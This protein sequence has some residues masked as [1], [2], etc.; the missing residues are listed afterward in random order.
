MRRAINALLTPALP[1]SLATL[2]GAWR[3]GAHWL[4]SSINP[5]VGLAALALA[6]CGVTYERWRDDQRTSPQLKEAAHANESL[7]EGLNESLNESLNEGLNEHLKRA[8]WAL[9][10]A[11]MVSALALQ[12]KMSPLRSLNPLHPALNERA[13][14]ALSL[15][16]LALWVGWWAWRASLSP[17]R[18]AHTALPLLSGLFALPV[19]AWLRHLDEPLQVM[20]AELGLWVMRRVSD[21]LT[22]VGSDP[23]SLKSWDSY[24]FY[25]PNFYL[26]INE[27]C[28]GVNLLLSSAL[29]AVGFA[30]VMRAGLKGALTLLV[31]ALP[32]ALLLNGVRIALIFALGHF[33]SVELAM[34]AWHEG[35]AYLTQLPLL[36]FLA[37]RCPS[38]KRA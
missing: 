3:L 11:L 14:W 35:S 27:T 21:A 10:L 32:L 33:G 31:W 5:G 26:I 25:S 2:F 17:L 34:G 13:L 23:I 24:T 19:E 7:N 4:E 8:L 22:L 15:E 37:W 29:Y 28:S 30:W 16:G 36:V 38:P 12:L 6:L 18:R 20:G 9:S 1:L